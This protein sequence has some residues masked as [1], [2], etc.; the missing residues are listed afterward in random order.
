MRCK[1]V[2]PLLCVIGSWGVVT[3]SSRADAFGDD[4]KPLIAR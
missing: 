3:R 1:L 2:I 4:I